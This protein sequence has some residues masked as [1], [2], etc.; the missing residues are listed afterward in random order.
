MDLSLIASLNL[1]VSIKFLLISFVCCF[2]NLSLGVRYLHVSHLCVT[3][4]CVCKSRRIV[5]P[6]VSNICV[7][8]HSCTCVLAQESCP[9]LSLTSQ[10]QRLFSQHA[11]LCLCLSQTHTHTLTHI[12][13]IPSGRIWRASGSGYLCVLSLSLSL[14]LSYTHT[15]THTHTL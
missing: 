15:H 12:H 9:C 8:V 13:T 7:S 14:S 1:S 3:C 4:V 5:F 11:Y 6:A 2:D 10:G